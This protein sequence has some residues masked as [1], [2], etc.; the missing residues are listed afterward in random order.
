MTGRRKK[1]AQENNSIFKKVSS[2]FGSG[3]LV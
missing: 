1:K 2:L 3:D